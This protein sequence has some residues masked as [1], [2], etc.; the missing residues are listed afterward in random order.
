MTRPVQDQL[1]SFNFVLSAV[2]LM[3]G[4]VE[5]RECNCEVRVS[6]IFLLP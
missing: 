2:L 4:N 5:N 1:L 3:V 6:K